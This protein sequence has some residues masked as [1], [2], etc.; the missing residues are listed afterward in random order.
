M[1]SHR[2]R[3]GLLRGPVAHQRGRG[4]PGGVRTAW[5]AQAARPLRR[6]PSP[7]PLLLQHENV[8]IVRKRHMHRLSSSTHP[9]ESATHERAIAALAQQ[10]H[11]PIDHVAQ[12]YERELA[13]L[14]VGAR[15]TG[16][17]AILTTRKVR[18][19]LRQRRH[20]AHPPEAPAPRQVDAR[21]QAQTAPPDRTVFSAPWR[22]AQ[23]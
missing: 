23:H 22:P 16:F 21:A 20:P 2:G 7:S 14:T 13:V 11:V 3:H 1:S 15:I 8:L 17:L 12:L 6:P 4:G 5:P 9:R 10:S 18:E 19:I